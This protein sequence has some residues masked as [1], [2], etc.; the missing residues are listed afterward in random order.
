[1]SIESILKTYSDVPRSAVLKY[2]LNRMGFAMSAAALE[3]VRD[4]DLVFKGEFMFSLD[5]QQRRS[6]PQKVPFSLHFKRDD[7]FFLN[8]TNDDSPY[9]IDFMRGKFFLTDQGDGGTPFEEIYF[10]PTPHY[11][12]LKTSDGIPMS[13]IAQPIG[14]RLFVT[15][16]K[17]CEYFKYGLECKFCDLT[18]TGVAQMQDGEVLHLHR[19][20]EQIAE[21][22][23][24][25]FSEISPRCFRH[26]AISGGTIIT[27]YKNG[28]SELDYYVDI[29]N[30]V[31]KRLR[32]FYPSYIQIC[33]P[34]DKDGWKRL[35]DTGVASVQPDLEVMDKEKFEW[36]CPGKAKY[37]GYNE[38]IRRLLEGVEVFGP[39]RIVPNFVAG[40]EMAKPYG[41]TDIEEA[42]E[43][44]LKGFDFLMQNGV[45]PR[46]A[47]WLIVKE[48]ALA[49]VP[50]QEPPPLEYCIRLGK[51]YK[52]LR[53]KYGFHDIP[54]SCRGCNPQDA[55]YDWDYGEKEAKSLK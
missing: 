49:R 44:D 38:W 4:M 20:T 11:F 19:T 21:T 16:N 9:V 22:L 39:G 32:A 24:A 10:E 28:K 15:V 5:R 17:Y 34:E 43:S 36:I 23:E 50:G 12:K 2:E 3:A 7:T 37:I 41:F 52:K 48:S 31:R 18:P 25:A 27:T 53:D 40:C 55:L 33:P 46:M 29:L 47:V 13:Q 1:M 14:C 45:F 42:V 26:L 6:L 8:R 35:L 30:G 54:G 51:G